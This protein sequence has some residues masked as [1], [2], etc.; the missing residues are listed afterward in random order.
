MKKF[1]RILL[2]L[3]IVLVLILVIRTLTY[4][5]MQID[6]EP[7][8]LPAFGMESVDNL[9]RAITF[10]TISH[11]VSLPVDTLAFMGFHQFLHETYPLV[12][13]T[14][15]KEIFSE[16]SLLYTWEGRNPELKPVILMAHMDVVPAGETDAWQQPPFSGQNDGTFIWGRGTLD[17]KGALIAILEAVERLVS[18]DYQ[19]SRTIYLSFGHDEEISGYQGAQG[20]A[21]TLEERGVEAAFVLDEGL[22]I[23]KGIVPMI[24]KPVASIGISEKGYLSLALTV[25]ME[26]GHSSTPE[27]ESAIILLNG[28]LHNLI[29][30]QMKAD[31]AGPAK[32]FMRFTGPEMPFLPKIIFANQ[33]LLKGI[34]LKI[35]EGSNAGN[36]AIRTTTAPTVIN[37]G[38]KDNMIPTK[39]EAVVNFR[40]IPWETSE[41]V[42]RHVHRVIS[43][44]R[45][46]V[47]I[48]DHP[49]E[50]SPVS[51]IDSPGFEL[52]HATIRQ[53]FPEVMVNP[54]LM[55][56]AS[57]SRHFTGMSN[58][59]YRF[60]PVTFTQEDLA[61]AHGLDERI[62]IEDFKK[63]MGFYYV[64]IK[65]INHL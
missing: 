60:I 36:A 31:I 38:I 47:T 6:V 44:D 64:L 16:F 4:R 13:A 9:A 35:Y 61:R 62:G 56:G 18:E 45:V 58:N 42:I 33:W 57:D 29:N 28:A 59:I 23:S 17:D 39:A 1:L 34:I 21:N 20:I 8:T 3:F 12:H 27:K 15:K 19:P 51:P 25:E 37:A 55:L 53:V 54:M 14:L 41:D 30:K 2:G 52:I 32:D 65:N 10:P 7:V 26:G 5:S 49:R 63:A 22:V 40:I 11:D 46:K 48:V 24:D 43:D 50:P